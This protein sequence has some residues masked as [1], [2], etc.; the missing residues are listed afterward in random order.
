MYHMCIGVR[1]GGS[2]G[3]VDP[4]NSGRYMTFIRAK[5]NTYSGKRQHICLTNCVT[6]NGTSIHL[7][8]I[9]FGWVNKGDVHRV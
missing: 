3:A 5:D 4:P 7:P 2:G 8:E 9:H 1:D 6:P